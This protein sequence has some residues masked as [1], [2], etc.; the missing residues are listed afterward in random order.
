MPVPARFRSSLLSA[1]AACALLLAPAAPLHAE[2]ITIQHA[3]GT[4][5]VPLDPKTIL[6]FDLAALDTLNTLGVPV[7]GVPEGVKPAY[8]RHYNEAA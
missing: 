8:L 2:T 1:L 5:E 3:Q 4:S 7:A 6:V